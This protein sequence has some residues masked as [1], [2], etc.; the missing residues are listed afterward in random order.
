M[1][2]FWDKRFGNKEYIYGEAANQFFTE[3]L[4]MHEP[5][6]IL[7]PAEGEGRNAVYAAQKGWKVSAFDSSKEGQKKA[8]SLAERKSVSINY[9]LMSADD[10]Q[11]VESYDAVA[12]IYAHF[13]EKDRTAFFSK[14]E[15]SLRKDGLLIVEVFSK[16][17]LGRDSGGPKVLDLLY[18]AQEFRDHFPSMHFDLLEEQEVT[19][20]EGSYH[21]GKAMVIRAIARKK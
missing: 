18:E 5:G 12:L 7:L 2:S 17:Q 6:H 3:S 19:L 1:E 16:R 15:K 14:L 11:P 4:A 9:A 10:F 13:M 21:Q 8:L 20:D